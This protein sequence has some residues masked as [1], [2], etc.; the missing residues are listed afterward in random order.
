MEPTIHQDLGIGTLDV[1]TR[2]IVRLV[3][4]Q[5][6]SVGTGIC[7]SEIH[8]AGDTTGTAPTIWYFYNSL[9]ERFSPCTGQLRVSRKFRELTQ[10]TVSFPFFLEILIWTLSFSLWEFLIHCL[11]ALIKSRWT[12]HGFVPSL[13]LL[14]KYVIKA[15]HYNQ[16]WS[17]HE[18]F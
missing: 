4:F 14:L 11:L 7:L 12:H 18:P 1:D 3:F 8:T 2:R 9:F 13:L 17:H 6:R 5:S 15:E 16:V 10:I